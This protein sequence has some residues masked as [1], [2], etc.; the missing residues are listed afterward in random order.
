MIPE[1]VFTLPNTGV[2]VSKSAV[3]IVQ[4]AFDNGEPVFVLRAKD[5]F[6]LPVIG[7]YLNRVR[8]YGPTNPSY[9]KDIEHIFQAFRTWQ[10]MHLGQVRYPD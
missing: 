4:S 1:E 7:E 5:I 8:Q 2:E 9:E 6:S 3:G 10:E